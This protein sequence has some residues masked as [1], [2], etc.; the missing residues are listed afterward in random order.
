MSAV[1]IYDTTLRDGTQAEELSLTCEDKVRISLKLDEFGVA[2]IEGGWP[3]SNP[4]DKRFFKEIANYSLKNARVAAFGSTHN[5][6][7]KAGADANI[8]ALIEAATPV[9]T[10]F[11][12]A[13]DIHATLAL[14][15]SLARNLELIA[16]SLGALRPHCRELFFDAEHFFDGFKA[17][18]DYA[19]AALRAARD[20]GADMLVLCDT[21]GGTLT[22]EIGEIVCA[23]GRELPGAALAIH[24]H[25]DSGL[26][27][28]N[29]LEAVRQGAVQVQGTINGYGE[30]C[31][32]AN[33]C[34]II[35]CLELKMSRACLPEGKLADL[36]SVSRFVSEIANLK[37]FGR[38]P[39]V[40]DSAFAH[41]GGIH[42]S[43]VAKD[44]LTYEHIAPE[45]VGNKQRILL[46]DLAGQSNILFKA[47][48]YGFNLDKNDPF[49]LE[50][51]TQIKERESKGYDY[52]TAEASF[53]LMLNRTLGRARR[54]FELVKYRVF[55]WKQT[56]IMEP[57]AEATVIVKVGGEEEHTASMGMGPVNA[58]DNALRK[59]LE[60]FYPKLKEMTLLDFKVR[61]LAP[62]GAHDAGTASLVRVLIESGDHKHDWVTVGVSHNIIEACWQALEDSF[63]YKLFI[64]D[65]EKLTKAL[66]E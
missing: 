18:R 28:A 7:N 35:P 23:V 29:S 3:G 15:V 36:T 59:A 2:Y 60:T 11:G 47:K 44:P 49:V 27:V 52:T 56:E 5:P 6:K 64:D 65:K 55:G 24:A 26:A 50:L 51:V 32:N 1:S 4:T 9:V 48:A 10:I 13:W 31:G 53:E 39:F 41:K 58:L 8:K 12:K 61:V 46:S 63:N 21:N 17:N 38:A 43:A 19:L 16:D 34:A 14:G 30:R 37:P 66:R 22:H 42:V 40:G 33:L 25:N 20:S 57:L 62:S 45:L 54:Y